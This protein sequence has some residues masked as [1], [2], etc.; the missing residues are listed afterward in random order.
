MIRLIADQKDE[1][2]ESNVNRIEVWEEMEKCVR[3][4]QKTGGTRGSVEKS[5]RRRGEE[6]TGGRRREQ[7]DN[8]RYKHSPPEGRV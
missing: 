7:S 6:E 2:V 4:G 8:H 3:K 1:G 5:E